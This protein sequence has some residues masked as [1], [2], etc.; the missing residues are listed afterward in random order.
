MKRTVDEINEKIKK[1]KVFVLTAQEAKAL[2][3]EKGIKNFLNDVDVVTCASFEMNVNALLYLNFGQT[4]PLIY[5]SEASINNVSAYATGPSDLCL[6]CVIPSSDNPKYGGAHILEELVQKKDVKL[7]AYGR[8]LEE[9]T[10]REFETWFNLNDL[11]QS[12]LLLNQAINQNDVVATNSGNMDINSHLGTLIGKLENSSFNSSSF[13]NPLI[14]DPFCKTIGVGT[15]VWVAGAQGIVIGQGSNH[16]PM[17]KRNNYDI[18]VGPAITLSVIADP[19]KM[20]P[21]W[22][23]GGYI[24]SFGPVLYIG[25][26]VPIPVLDEEIAERLSITDESIQT[27][28]VDFS[29]PRRAKPIFGKCTYEEL[30]TSTVVINKKPTLCSPMSSMAYALE[31]CSILKSEIN[32]GKFYLANHLSQI[33]LNMQMKK[34]D[35]RLVEPV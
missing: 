9:F 12:K 16:N 31:I 30:R 18:P 2:I 35:S 29:I 4:D 15:R 13:L 23:R 28:I 20:N 33:N 8:P 3:R 5:F 1:G 7:K 24:K 22:V 17:Q 11:N 34:M 14:N 27:T 6:S 25:I 10:N 26:G 19:V 21:K 32:N